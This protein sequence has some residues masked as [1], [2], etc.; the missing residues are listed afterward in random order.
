LRN[1]LAKQD[2]LCGL[3]GINSERHS[4]SFGF[5]SH[6]LAFFLTC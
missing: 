1:M 5:F 3:T 4:P 6:L 2:R